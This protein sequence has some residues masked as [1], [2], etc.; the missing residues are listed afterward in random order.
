MALDPRDHCIEQKHEDQQAEDPREDPRRIVSGARCGD[1]ETDAAVAAQKLPDDGS[2][3][4][5]WER[6]PH[7]REDVGRGTWQNEAW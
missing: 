1:E 3:Q 5:S 4:G 2:D 6:D 7:R